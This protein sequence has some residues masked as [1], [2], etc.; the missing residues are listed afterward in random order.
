MQKRKAPHETVDSVPVSGDPSQE[1][2]D[3]VGENSNGNETEH[4][5]CEL[6]RADCL[7]LFNQGKY[8]GDAACFFHCVEG[9]KGLLRKY[10]GDA[11]IRRLCA[12]SNV[13]LG[14]LCE[15]DAQA[16][17]FF[18][19]AIAADR[20]LAD[21]H[22]NLGLRIRDEDAAAAEHHFREAIQLAAAVL[23]DCTAGGGDGG[24]GECA[25]EHLS[26]TQARR[27]DTDAQEENGGHTL[28]I[29]SA[30]NE[31]SKND[32]NDGDIEEEEEEE[33]EEDEVEEEMSS[34]EQ[35]ELDAGRVAQYNLALLLS[36]LGGRDSEADAHCRALSFNYRLS[37]EVLA[38]ARGRKKQRQQ[39]GGDPGA[40]PLLPQQT[41]GPPGVPEKSASDK[42]LFV[43]THEAAIRPALLRQLQRNFSPDAPFWDEHGY[44]EE[45]GF[46]SYNYPLSSPPSNAV[47][48]LI[49][50]LRPVLEKDLAVR[51][52][53]N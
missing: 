26:A 17:T 45:P 48:V 40:S 39:R 20:S 12:R 2:V 41:S 19:K 36:Q 35:E 15:E 7:G 22:S 1:V 28:A 27:K 53:I 44:H 49:Q 50:S 9:C 34:F 33:E 18:R 11:D 42:H 6:S 25:A 16:A 4:Q 30:N 37:P 51:C 24:G 3:T 21:A 32:D 31:N 14:I 38:H 10:P 5:A 8:S 46:F 23:N 52:S 29:E 13:Q 47:E 43:R